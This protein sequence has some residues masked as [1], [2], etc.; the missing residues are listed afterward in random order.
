MLWVPKKK[1]KHLKFARSGK[2]EVAFTSQKGVLRVLEGNQKTWRRKSPERAITDLLKETPSFTGNEGSHRFQGSVEDK[3]F[4]AFF[5]IFRHLKT[6][7]PP[8]T[9]T[10]AL[11]DSRL[12]I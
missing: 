4:V 5:A 9:F 3:I 6:T 7:S 8:F 1:G 2:K 12:A 11:F 10:F